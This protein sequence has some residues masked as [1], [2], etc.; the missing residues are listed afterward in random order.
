[1]ENIVEVL[2]YALADLWDGKGDFV[3][4]GEI[5]AGTLFQ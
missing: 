4:T 2:D 1:M 5:R 3:G